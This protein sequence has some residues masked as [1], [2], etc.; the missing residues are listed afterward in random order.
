MRTWY[1]VG[2][3][4]KRPELPALIREAARRLGCLPD[5]ESIR[6]ERGWSR[7]RNGQGVYCGIG[8]ADTRPEETPD[9]PEPP[10]DADTLV[11]TLRISL[12]Q[13]G[14]I[15]RSILPPEL[16]EPFTQESLMSG[17]TVIHVVRTPPPDPEEIDS[18]RELAHSVANESIDT[19]TERYDRLLAWLSCTVT[20]TWGQFVDA[21]KSLGVLNFAKPGD[22]LV[23]LMLLGHIEIEADGRR[24]SVN[25]PMLCEATSGD[26]FLCGQRDSGILGQL[27]S[28]AAAS[29]SVQPHGAGPCQIAVAAKDRIDAEM[30][31]KESGSV[32]H[33]VENTGTRIAESLPSGEEWIEGV[34]GNVHPN[35]ADSLVQRIRIDSGDLTPVRPAGGASG[36]LT[37][38]EGVYVVTTEQGRGRSFRAYCH[39]DGSWTRCDWYGM[40]YLEQRRNGRLNAYLADGGIVLPSDGSWPRVY[41]RALVL[42]SGLLPVHVPARGRLFTTHNL[43]VPQILAAKLGVEL[44]PLEGAGL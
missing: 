2:Q 39:E 8:F 20:G 7:Q 30:L 1:L 35:L 28:R 26:W 3:V 37:V 44:Q 22:V 33:A 13:K 4:T 36:G 42:S 5:L 19:V 12:V 40:A 15:K 21:T 10:F 41:E 11:E 29:I 6:F 24:W 9:P 34:K 38:P 25:P 32:V 18:A 14:N 27:H 43:S 23:R 31:F 16:A 17:E